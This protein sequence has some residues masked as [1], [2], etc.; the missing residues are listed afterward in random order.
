MN[1]WL[2]TYPFDTV[3]TII[4]GGDINNKIKQKEVF[5]NLI[6]KYGYKSLCKGLTPTLSRGFITNAVVFYVN[7]ICQEMAKNFKI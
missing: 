7:E 5:R 6:N 2:F 1:A 3:K 4:Q